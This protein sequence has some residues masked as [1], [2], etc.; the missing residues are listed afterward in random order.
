MNVPLTNAMR[1]RAPGQR[2]NKDELDSL[3]QRTFP[4]AVFVRPP[5]G[6][7]TLRHMTLLPGASVGTYTIVGLLGSGGMGDVYKARDTR[8]GRMVAIKVLKDDLSRSPEYAQRLER[9]ARTI[10]G[11]SHPNICVLYDVG[12]L[13]SSRYLVMEFLEGE[14]VAERLR[15]GPL[16]EAE[17]LTCAREMANALA[18]AHAQGIVHRDLKPANVMLTRSGAKLMDFG[19][20]TSGPAASNSASPL[21]DTQSAPLTAR[22][23]IVGTPAYMSPERLQGGVAD[24]R[25]DIFAFGVVLYEMLAGV[26][27]FAGESPAQVIGAVIGTEPS[28]L[29]R[30][31]PNTERV[32]R[33][34]LQ[35]NPAD[36]WQRM[37]QV[38]DALS[39]AD[40]LP[41]RQGIKPSRRIAL[42]ATMLVVAVLAY[43][44]LAAPFWRQPLPVVVLMDST[45][46]ERVYDPVRLCCVADRDGG[47]RRTERRPE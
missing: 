12:M 9:E 2:N 18:I 11:L 30:V 29:A 15:R 21:A 6:S 13:G 1:S 7:S 19:L 31:S 4:L 37:E 46:P 41:R 35:K 34:C 17:A 47:Q 20:A 10:A 28:S 14:T 22:W 33:R 32:V 44:S 27:P 16:P 43:T 5:A 3:G 23:Q 25:A 36:R 8:L 45:F 39:A 42:A 40:R 38:T 24:A 26:R